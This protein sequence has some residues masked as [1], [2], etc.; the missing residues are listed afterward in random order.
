MVYDL[1]GDGK[2]EVVVKTADGT[3]DG[4]GTVIGDPAA[5]YTN[6]SGYIL[7]GP[8]FLTVFDGATGRALATTNYVPARGVVTSW[9]DNYG[10]RVDR[11]LAVVA[12]LD[13]VHP[14]VVMCRGYYTRTVLAA[15]DWRNGQLTQRWVFDSRDPSHPEYQAYEGQ[16]NHNLSVTDVDGDGKDDIVY[17]SAVINSNGTGRFSTGWGHG[18]AMHVSRFD[19]NNPDPLVFGV[20]ENSG[21]NTITCSASNPRYGS[22]LYNART[23]AL[24]WGTDLCVKKDFG[25][26]MVSALNPNQAGYDF[27]GGNLINGKYKIYDLKT[28]LSGPSPAP[29]TSPCGGTPI[30]NARWRTA[31]RSS[32]TISPPAPPAPSSTARSAPPT[33]APRPTP[34]SPAICSETGARR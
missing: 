28:I 25:R 18:D 29:R 8:E 17:G 5:N 24:V 15:W 33:T 23:G 21:I 26:G 3:T 22:T 20:H 27:W 6:K 1:D 9:G 19:P 16:G 2:A 13:G 34:C 31:P 10:N 11:F 4:L 32:N 30:C 7:S 12:Y 14:S